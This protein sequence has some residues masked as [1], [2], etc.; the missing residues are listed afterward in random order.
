VPALARGDAERLIRFVGEAE[1][2]GGED[3]PFSGDLLVELGRLVAADWVTYYEHDCVPSGRFVE[4]GRTGDSDQPY[5]AESCV[6]DLNEN[7]S[8]CVAGTGNSVRSGSR[9]F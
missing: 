2:L 6:I 5:I 4:V 1:S 8:V 3:H 9:T 7:R